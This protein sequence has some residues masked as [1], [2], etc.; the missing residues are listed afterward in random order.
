MMAVLDQKDH[1]IVVP[2]NIDDDLL[3]YLLTFDVMAA[4]RHT[5]TDNKNVLCHGDF[6]MWNVAFDK[7]NKDLVLFDFQEIHRGHFANDIHHYLSQTTTPKDRAKNLDGYLNAYSKSFNDTAKRLELTE[8]ETHPFKNV[9]AAYKVQ[10]PI[11]YVCGMNFLLRRFVEDD[12]MYARME[13]TDTSKEKLELF[14]K[15]GD[16]K[17]VWSIL[18]VIFDLVG[19]LEA[20][21][22]FEIT[23]QLEA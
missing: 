21:G 4:F 10:S 1:R 7:D 11:S 19:E 23:K 20:M 5:R 17:E 13:A 18:Q 8:C 2:D 12:E 9:K 15:V 16:E 6:H 14:T 3:S 22:T